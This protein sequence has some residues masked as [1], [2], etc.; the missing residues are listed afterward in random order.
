M[1]SRRKTTIGP[2]GSEPPPMSVLMDVFC[3]SMPVLIFK[4]SQGRKPQPATKLTN[5]CIWFDEMPLVPD[6]SVE[7]VRNVS[8][9]STPFCCQTPYLIEVIKSSVPKSR[10]RDPVLRLCRSLIT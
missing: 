4:Y 6:G 2:N 7:P 9:G 8:I 1:L 10:R 3:Q 5:G